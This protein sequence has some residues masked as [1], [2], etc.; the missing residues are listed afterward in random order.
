MAS[1]TK[2]TSLKLLVVGSWSLAKTVPAFSMAFKHFA[3]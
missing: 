3:N 1:R 2:D